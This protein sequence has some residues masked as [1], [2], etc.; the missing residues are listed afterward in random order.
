MGEEN[1]INI[2]GTVEVDEGVI[3][4]MV[5]YVALTSYGVAGMAMPNLGDGIAKMLPA[6]KLRRGILLQNHGDSVTVELYIVVQY[7]TNLSTVAE[8]L[9]DTVRYALEEYL[10]VPVKDISVNIQGIKI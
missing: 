6:Q 7:G 1:G 10:Q 3:Q 8:N 4:D 2:P 5:G 9:A